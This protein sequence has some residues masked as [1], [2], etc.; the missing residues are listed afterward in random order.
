[1]KQLIEEGHWRDEAG[2]PAGGSTTAMGIH[3]MWQDG[4]LGRGDERKN[5]NG[6]FVE[7]VI[8]AA[9]GRLEFYQQSRFACHENATAIAFLVGALGVLDQRTKYRELRGRRRHAHTL[10]G[11]SF[12]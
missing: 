12:G 3:I 7:G 8:Q 10:R 4:P 2:N 11:Q 9:I 1:M 6:A 5:A